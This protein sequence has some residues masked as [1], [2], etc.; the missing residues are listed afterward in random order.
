MTLTILLSLITTEL[1]QNT[2]ATHFWS[3]S[4][5]FNESGIASVIT[6]LMLMLAVNGPNG[7]FTPG[8]IQKPIKNDCTETDTSIEFHWV[9]YPFYRSWYRSPSV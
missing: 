7:V 6:A 1:L 9:L 2:V 3:D 5:V 8:S 4:V